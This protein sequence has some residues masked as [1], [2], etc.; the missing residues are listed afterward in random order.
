MIEKEM[1]TD[2]GGWRATKA[3]GME[4]AAVGFAKQG[5]RGGFTERDTEVEA[6]AALPKDMVAMDTALPQ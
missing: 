5:F 2:G 3:E 6:M 4:V 1:V